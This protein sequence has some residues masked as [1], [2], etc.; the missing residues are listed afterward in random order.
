MEDA[1]EEVAATTPAETDREEE[2]CSVLPE[3]TSKVIPK[4]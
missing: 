1:A 4:E 2:D 3:L